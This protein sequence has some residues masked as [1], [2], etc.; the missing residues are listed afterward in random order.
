MDS[1][2]HLLPPY[3]RS[4]PRHRRLSDLPLNVSREILQQSSDAA[5]IRAASVEARAGPARGACGEPADQFATF[6]EN[7]GA[8]SRKAIDDSANRD[9]IAKLLRFATTH[10]DSADQVV[11]L[12]DYVS[13]MKPGQDAIYYVTADGF[14]AAR[15]SPHLEVFRKYGVEALL[16]GDRVDEWVVSHLLEFEG[17]KLQ[18][19]SQGDLDLGKL[20]EPSSPV[21]D[22]AKGDEYKELL[23]RM[24]EALKDQAGGV[25]L[26]HRLTDS[27]AC[28]V[29]D[30]RGM[31]RHMER[32][33]SGVRPAFR[34]AGRF[35]DQPGTPIVGG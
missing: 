6:W 31:S 8:C 12:T 27:P 18:S 24:Q 14:A 34:R 21:A 10:T 29:G 22:E 25:R 35:S 7:S 28:L 20:G 13:R 30:A 5:L 11:S 32:I 26:T 19:A 4:H 15:N 3:L 23:T 33:L 1:G 17:R 9:R 2:E 16:L